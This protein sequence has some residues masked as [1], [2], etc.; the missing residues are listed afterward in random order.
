MLSVK[1]LVS[2]IFTANEEPPKEDIAFPELGINPNIYTTTHLDPVGTV[3]TTPLL[4]VIGPAD[5]ALDPLGIL[6]ETATV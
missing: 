6:Y 3:T 2:L 1:V 5:I 4:T